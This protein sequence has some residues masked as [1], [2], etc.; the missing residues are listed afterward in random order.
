MALT[1]RKLY[2]RDSHSHQ[3]KELA[4]NL[5]VICCKGHRVNYILGGTAHSRGHHALGRVLRSHCLADGFDV[6]ALPYLLLVDQR[7]LQL[8]SHFSEWSVT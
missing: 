2:V 5:P 7:L 4:A 1:G 3:H 6:L 8:V